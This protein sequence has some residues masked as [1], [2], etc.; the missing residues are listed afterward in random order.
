WIS[1][2]SIDIS[3]LWKNYTISEMC[4]KIVI[5]M[6]YELIISYDGVTIM[7]KNC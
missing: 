6:L 4:I 5:R 1:H 2:Y 7:H 3:F